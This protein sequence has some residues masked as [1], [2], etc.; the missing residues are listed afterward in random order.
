[1]KLFCARWRKNPALRYQQAGDLKTKVETI[2]ITQQV[3]GSRQEESQIKK[4]QPR[5]DW[6]AH[7]TKTERN[8]LSILGLLC[9]AWIAGTV[10]GIP[11]LLRSY[12][13]PGNWIVASVWGILFVVSIP[14]IHRII[15]HFLCSTAWAKDRGFT[16]E[17]LRQFS[18]RKQNLWKVLV[19]LAAGLALI[20][21]QNKAITS[22]LGLEERPRSNQAGGLV[23]SA[24]GKGLVKQV[25]ATRARKGYIPVSIRYVG[26]VES[27]NSVMF[28]IA[29]EYSQAVIRK[30]DA[31]Q[32]LTVEADNSHGDRF[33][34]GF[35]SGVD[36]RIDTATGTLKC[37]ATL[38]PEGDNL[39]V[40]GLFLNIRLFLGMKPGV[41]LVP[42]VAIQHDPQSAFV[43]VIQVYHT[44]TRRPV[45]VG[46]VDGG[47]AEIQSGLS[48]GE[49]VVSDGFAGLHEGQRVRYDLDPM[50]KKLAQA[51]SQSDEQ[52][53]NK[54][55]EWLKIQSLA[56]WISDLQ[57]P[58][59]NVQKTAERALTDMGTNALPGFLKILSE[60]TDSS[61][62]DDL[63]RYNTAHALR[64]MGNGVKGGLPAFTALLQSGDQ[65][66]A[67]AGARALAFSAPLVPEAFSILTNALTDSTPGVREA[68]SHGV[69][70][71][72]NTESNGFAESALPLLVRNLSD[73]ID[74][75]RSDTAIALQQY[76]NRQSMRFP[77]GDAKPELLVPP[78]IE[79]LHDK[80]SF[81]RFYAS[82]ALWCGCYRDA[83]KPWIPA[84][85]KLLSDPDD[86]VRQSAT[87]FL[88]MLH[89]GP[90]TNTA[91]NP[92][93]MQAVT[94]KAITGTNPNSLS[95]QW[96]LDTNN[97]AGATNAVPK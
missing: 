57:S 81:A 78:L 82:E 3:D 67:Y 21:A 8:L 91:Q 71:C 31:H 20:F 90:A 56:G 96:V 44:L 92:S 47:W 64:F 74:Y 39:M 52:A 25:S 35:L 83:I 73:K 45:S 40:P 26:T 60:S 59:P 43:W 16:T 29:E 66:K 87:N 80:Y 13:S 30:F 79:L 24:I 76:A 86:G 19:V 6:C 97:A 33:G 41:T 10:F 55:L 54:D 51:S 63:R 12:P 32:E 95:Y 88:Q 28:S 27:S 37:K 42:I 4:P 15:N 50:S 5:Q 7:L 69:G 18:F 38:F 2:A 53:S 23:P 75:V 84:V 68:A 72:L 36:N 61:N 11:A 62:D 17:S 77:P 49:I 94:F 65:G 58:D 22:Y 34:H 1:M 48:S 46:V 85:Q 9:S 89:I 14:R 70:L 93:M